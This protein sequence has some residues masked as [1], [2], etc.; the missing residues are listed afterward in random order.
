MLQLFN[1]SEKFHFPCIPSQ[2]ATGEC[3]PPKQGNKPRKVKMRNLGSRG[4]N[5]T[6]RPRKLRNDG[7]ERLQGVHTAA[8]LGK[9]VHTGT[10]E[11]VVGDT[12]LRK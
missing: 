6:N 9:L 11:E 12:S 5:A 3:T 8:S 4:F 7:G 2:K 1:V 10:S